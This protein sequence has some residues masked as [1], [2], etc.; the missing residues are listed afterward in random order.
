[1]SYIRKEETLEL[2]VARAIGEGSSFGDNYDSIGPR[3]TNH[4]RRTL[5]QTL[6]RLACGEVLDA[7]DDECIAAMGTALVAEAN[8]I[9]PGYGTRILNV[10]TYEDILF[11]K[12]L[13]DLRWLILRWQSFS[14]VRRQV[15]GRLAARRLLST[16]RNTFQ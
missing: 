10:C 7:R 13:E 2:L 4:H 14:A 8:A 11:N 12:D 3:I 1:M 9:R 6:E 16:E 15:R 5:P